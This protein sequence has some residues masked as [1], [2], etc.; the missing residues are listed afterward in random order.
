MRLS[1]IAL[2]T[3]PFVGMSAGIAV[4]ADPK[5]HADINAGGEVLEFGSFDC[6]ANNADGRAVWY[7]PAQSFDLK[8]REAPVVYFSIAGF[9]HVPGSASLSVATGT[10]GEVTQEGFQ[11]SLE[12]APATGTEKASVSVNW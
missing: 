3:L 2:V 11:P 9:A 12:V 4:A 6:V 1:T 5:P 8:F 7:C 10:K